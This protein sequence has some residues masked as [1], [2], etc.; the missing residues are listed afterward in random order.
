[1]NDT[2]LWISTVGEGII[3]VILNDATSIPIVKS[4]SRTV[5][6]NG[7]MASNYFFTS[8]QENDSILWFGNRGCGAYRM[9]V[10]RKNGSI[11]FDDIANSQTA[12][13]IFAIYKMQK[14]IG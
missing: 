8:Y 1:M 5:I 4:A 7:R 11:S 9:N 13:D 10:K 14:A 6:D 3:K 12:N 2:T